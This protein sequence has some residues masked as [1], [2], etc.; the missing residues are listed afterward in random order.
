MSL[1][2]AFAHC[3]RFPAAASRRSGGRVSVPLC[4]S[5]LSHRVPVFG[6]VGHYP[7]NYLIGRKPV[8]KRLRRNGTF[9]TPQ[10]IGASLRGIRPDFSGLSPASGLVTYVLL[11]RLPLHLPDKVRQAPFDLHA[12]GAPPAFV[13]SQDQTLVDLLRFLPLSNC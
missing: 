10:R 11:S 8:P 6:L 9:P 2:Q 3:A 12:L 5:V 1:R 13:L 4:P 7:A